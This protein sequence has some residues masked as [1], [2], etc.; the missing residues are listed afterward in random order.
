MTEFM[1]LVGAESVQRAASTISSAAEQMQRA[2]SQISVDVDRLNRLQQDF[3]VSLEQ[4]INDGKA[5][6]L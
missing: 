2:A 1:H 5:S 3:L 4:I 6:I